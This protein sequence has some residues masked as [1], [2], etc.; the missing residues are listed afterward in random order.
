MPIIWVE[1]EDVP[2]CPVLTKSD[3]F[4]SPIPHNQLLCGIWAWLM[5]NF[6]QPAAGRT[7]SPRRQELDLV[8]SFNFKL[9]PETRIAH[10][11]N[12][13]V[14]AILGAYCHEV[15]LVINGRVATS[16]RVVG[17]G[18]DFAQV[19]YGEVH[20]RIIT[21]FRP[22]LGSQFLSRDGSEDLSY[23]VQAAYSMPAPAG[24]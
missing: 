20:D 6:S 15:Q 23:C 21:Q 19:R 17:N 16:E 8:G 3:S 24:E 14:A 7:K 2:G 22:L 9:D 4:F 13:G 18:C 5:P 10:A 12:N 11:A 1:I